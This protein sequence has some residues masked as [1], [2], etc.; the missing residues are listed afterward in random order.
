MTDEKY[1][2]LA[3]DMA[4]K[5]CGYVN[6]NPMVGAVIVKEG[7]IIGQGWHEK[8]GQP[9]AERNALETCSE[10]PEEATMYVTLEPCCH[11]GKT[12]PCTDAILNSGIKKVVIGSRDPN[13][14]VSGNGI[15]A[16][17]KNGVK[18]VTGVLEAECNRLNEVFFHY[19]QMGTPFVVMKYAMTMDGKIATAAGNSKWITGDPARDNVHKDRHKYSA[20][21]VGVGT[22]IAD[23]PMLTCRLE[24]CR[25][26]VRIICDTNMRIPVASNLVTTADISETII[27]TSCEDLKR[28]KPYMEAG[29][30]ILTV[31]KK[32]NRLDLNI[33]MQQLGK[34]KIDSILLEGGSELN[35]SALQNKIVNKIHAY[36]SPKIFGGDKAKTPVGGI[37]LEEVQ[38]C[39]KLNAPK[40]TWFGE[41][42]LIE[43]E[44]IY[45]CLQE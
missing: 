16:L 7:R 42:L 5:G 22:V 8:Y 19:I 34:R 45:P 28:H 37:G 29:C 38:N 10:S 1:M 12:P 15:T 20:I 11:F 14:L 6:P 39:F 2:R 30:E 21:M 27:A 36:I 41:D 4:Q 35:F 26:P 9:H 18:V 33:L 43:S 40:A 24:N 44:V 23:N 13:P 17:K 3:L 32:N 25:Q 31:P